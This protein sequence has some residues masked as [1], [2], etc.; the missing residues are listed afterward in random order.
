M[1]L[2]HQL[3]F[4]GGD[5]SDWCNWPTLY[6]GSDHPVIKMA[7]SCTV[8]IGSK[9]GKRLQKNVTPALQSVL[10]TKPLCY[11]STCNLTREP[12]VYRANRWSIFCFIPCCRTKRGH[13][14]LICPVCLGEMQTGTQENVCV[15]CGKWNQPR[16]G[17]CPSCGTTLGGDV[18]VQVN[19]EIVQS[20][21]AKTDQA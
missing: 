19:M 4:G 14:I 3:P 17:F 7:D 6:E 18:D 8:V 15:G 1:R 5:H 20:E 10:D 13:E 16:E 2:H 11:C 12:V 9:L 21:P